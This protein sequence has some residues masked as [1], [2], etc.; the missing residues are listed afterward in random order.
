LDASDREEL[1]IASFTPQDAAYLADCL[2]LRDVARHIVLPEMSPRVKAERAF[3]WVCRH[4]WLHPWLVNTEQGIIATALPP[5]AVLR[6]GTGS[7]LERMY[8]FLALLQQLGLDGCL[9]GPAEADK[10][11]AGHVAMQGNRVLTDSPRGP[12]WAVA[13]REEDDLWLFDPWQEAAFPA[14]W[15]ALH[16][17][18]SAYAPWFATTEKGSGLS[19]QAWSSA[20]VFLAVP[21]A[22]LSPRMHQLHKKLAEPLQVHLAID[23]EELHRRFA[24]WQPRFWNPPEDRFAY[25]RTSR[26]FLPP[27]HGGNDTSPVGNRLFDLYYLTQLPQPAQVVP[28]ELRQNAA[29]MRDVG[30][31]IAQ[32]ARTQYALRFLEPPTP[33][34]RIQRGQFQEAARLL[35]SLQDE[36]GR[37]LSRVRNTPHVDQLRR[38]WI[39]QAVELYEQ[40]GRDPDALA[41]IEQHW[42]T[43]AAAVLLDQAVCEVGQAEA[44]FLLALCQHEQ[45]ERLQLRYEQ[46]SPAD[47][48][49]LREDAREAWNIAARAWR[50]YRG[51]Y[52]AFQATMPGRAPLADRLAARAERLTRP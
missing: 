27:D 9:I 23:P 26:T 31:R 29:L 17:D 28:A 19:Q 51:Q 2:Y 21:L 15:K 8:V 4:V 35:V 36:F 24:T 33:R 37:G 16:R 43:E 41:R 46:A 40:I 52:A 39:Q 48:P 13:V 50:T 1:T 10:H 3:A 22:A 7:G 25:G 47:A 45:A 6:R 5:T 32:V 34:E 44:T 49:R 18:P 30:E 20:K 38:D 11:H 42:R 14:S 12:F